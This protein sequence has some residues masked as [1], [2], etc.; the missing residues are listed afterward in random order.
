ME[1]LSKKLDDEIKRL[2]RFY[3]TKRALL[4]P[5]LH[6]A[7]KKYGWLPDDI[8][9]LVAKKLDLR[10]E[11]VVEVVTFYTMYN[12]EPVGRHHVQICNNIACWLRGSEDLIHQ[13]EE[14][15]GIALGETTKDGKFTLNEVECLGSCGTAPVCQINDDYYENLDKNGF[16]RTLEGLS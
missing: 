3:P 7:Q 12:K 8:Q 5:L 2:E 9:E 16:E 1:D 4:L 11:H 14:K 15:Y 6:V 10:K 13:F